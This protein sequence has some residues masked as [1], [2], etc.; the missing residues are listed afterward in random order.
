LTAAAAAIGT[1]RAHAY[2]FRKENEEFR[3][4]CEEAL[5]RYEGAIQ[6]EV[7]RRGVEGIEV[8]VLYDGAVVAV[9]RKYSDPLLMMEAKRVIPEYRE[10]AGGGRTTVNVHATAT[11]AAQG[12][13]PPNLAGVDP[14]KLNRAQREA[15]RAFMATLVAESPPMLDVAESA[16][17]TT[18][19]QEALD[20]PPVDASELGGDSPGAG[21]PAAGGKPSDA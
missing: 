15:Y 10:A 11:A 21:V 6:S 4:L 12:A 16:D 2:L 5:A 9:V 14:S 1:S 18:G 3:E 8:P 13:G 7:Y 19:A 20:C 17:G